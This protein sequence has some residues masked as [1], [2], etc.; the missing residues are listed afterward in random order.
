MPNLAANN[1]TSYGG[2]LIN[3]KYSPLVDIV[4]PAGD[5]EKT[6]YENLFTRRITALSGQNLFPRT[7]TLLTSGLPT[8]ISVDTPPMVVISSN[9]AEWM[10]LLFESGEAK[11]SAAAFTGY[12]DITT[13]SK[14]PVPWYA[15]RRS[16]RPVYIVVHRLE[17]PYYKKLLAGFL[18]VY[19]VGWDIPSPVDGIGLAGFGASRFAAFELVKNLGYHHVWTVDDNVVNI[20][21]FPNTLAEIEALMTAEI[22]GIGF[23]AATTNKVNADLSSAVFTPKRFDF[24]AM[25]AGLLQQVVLWNMDLLNENDLNISPYFVSSNEDVSLTNYLQ[26]WEYVE[27]TIK[28]LA[29]MK[30]DPSKDKKNGGAQVLIGIRTRLIK[31]LY[32]LEKHTKINT[33]SAVVDLSQFVSETIVPRS[34]HGTGLG[35]KRNGVERSTQAMAI[36]QVLAEVVSRKWAPDIVFDPYQGFV[37]NKVERQMA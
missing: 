10:Q 11:N 13:F 24:A 8:P 20:N 33:G 17:Y 4:I 1:N 5:G 30:M 32:D 28:P 9:R 23:A 26:T 29:I 37:G 25:K 18:N 35:K 31:L 22:A 16:G 6:F 7:L 19:V 15:P 27:R 14:G 3:Q 36:E 21:G 2:T 12:N 34:Q